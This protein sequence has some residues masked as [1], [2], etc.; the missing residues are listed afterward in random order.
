MEGH[1]LKEL[2]KKRGWTLDQVAQKLEISTTNY[3]NYEAGRRTPS[4]QKLNE[5]AELFNVPTDYLLGRVD[6]VDVK[7]VEDNLHDYLKRKTVVWNGKE[8]NEKELKLVNDFLEMV[9]D[10]EEDKNKK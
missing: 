4:I 10:R 3:H 8:L 7:K 9:L 1:R 6:D 5:L 2:R